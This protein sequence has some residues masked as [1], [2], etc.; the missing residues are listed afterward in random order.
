MFLL[1]SFLFSLVHGVVTFA[2]LIIYG[3]SF[4]IGLVGEK[5]H[6]MTGMQPTNWTPIYAGVLNGLLF[7]LSAWWHFNPPMW[8]FSVPAWYIFFCTNSF[9]WG[10]ALYIMIRVLK[11]RRMI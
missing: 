8:I 2:I 9:L 10:I 11:H 3:H 7:P 6:M 1:R 5:G 4:N